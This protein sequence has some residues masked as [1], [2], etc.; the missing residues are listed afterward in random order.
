[1][2]IPKTNE[3]ILD[4]RPKHGHV[5]LRMTS[6]CGKFSGNAFLSDD[7]SDEL[8]NK[9]YH[10]KNKAKKQKNKGEEK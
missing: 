6:Q 9:I 10:A 3:V 7:Q 5:W 8:I 4:V 2:T 1:M